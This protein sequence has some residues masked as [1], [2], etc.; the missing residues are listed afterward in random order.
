LICKWA[1]RVD[2][3]GTIIPDK[4]T[5][6][7]AFIDF[8]ATIDADATS[9]ISSLTTSGGVTHHI[10]ISLNGTTAWIPCSTTDPT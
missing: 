8:N 10:Q 1:V 3:T 4:T 2:N 6:D 9:A 5:A 7:E